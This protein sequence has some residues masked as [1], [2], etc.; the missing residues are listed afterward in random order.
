MF[1]LQ[2]SY[3]TQY[4]SKSFSNSSNNDINIVPVSSVKV[5][6]GKIWLIDCFFDKTLSNIKQNPNVD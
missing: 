4:R 6:E 5:I 2:R 3:I 1:I